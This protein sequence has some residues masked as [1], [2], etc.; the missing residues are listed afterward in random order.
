MFALS[1]SELGR[2]SF[3]LHTINTGDSPTIEQQPRRTPF[4][5]REK[6]SK[7]IDE[8]QQRGVVQPSASAWASSM[9]IVP[10][11]DGTSQFCV[12]FCTV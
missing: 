12:D 5:Q 3:V 4:I 11:K 6:V 7:L 8:M 1:D 2:T 10:N 9:V